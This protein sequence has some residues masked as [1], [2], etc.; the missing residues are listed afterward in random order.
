[1]PCTDFNQ[2]KKN[3][4]FPVRFFF[5]LGEPVQTSGPLKP[6]LLPEAHICL[7]VQHWAA[8]F[9]PSVS[10]HRRKFKLISITAISSA[11]YSGEPICWTPCKS[12]NTNYV[13]P[14]QLHQCS[15]C[16]WSKK[17]NGQRNTDKVLT[18]AAQLPWRLIMAVFPGLLDKQ[19]KQIGYHCIFMKAMKI[20][21]LQYPWFEEGKLWIKSCLAG[22][23]AMNV[24]TGIQM[25]HGAKQNVSPLNLAT[26][27]MFCSSH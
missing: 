23:H 1:M 7:A 26:V 21:T 6:A 11:V 27:L 9:C 22:G 20:L 12:R 19:N 15:R 3:I 4:C 16:V 24:E 14:K 17:K 8:D 10:L 25:E 18:T 5:S 13:M 2:S